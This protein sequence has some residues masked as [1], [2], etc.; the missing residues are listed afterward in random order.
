[1]SESEIL[2]PDFS[3][4]PNKIKIDGGCTYDFIKHVVIHNSGPF[5]DNGCLHIKWQD[6]EAL[7]NRV[8]EQYAVEIEQAKA[9]LSVKEILAKVNELSNKLDDIE[10]KIP[11]N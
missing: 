9:F 6:E 3:K 7:A 2:V 8:R 1:M 10:K 11:D 4:G 5:T